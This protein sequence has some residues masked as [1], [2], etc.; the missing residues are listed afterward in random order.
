MFRSLIA[1]LAAAALAG[2][3][4][5]QQQP[6]GAATALELNP[7]GLGHLLVV[8]YFNTQ[9]GN[10]TLVNLFNASDKD[11]V[12]KIRYRS[13][14]NGDD[15]FS[16]QVFLRARAA[17]TTNVSTGANGLPAL[18]GVDRACTLPATVIG[19]PFRTT[20]LNPALTAAVRANEAREGYI[21]IIA[22]ADVIP[23]TALSAA[24]AYR[25][26]APLC[27]P[28]VLDGLTRFDA[29]LAPPTTGLMA[30]WILINV[31]QTTT[32]SGEAV[33]YEARA[34]GIAS[35][36]NNVFFPQ[37]AAP[38]TAAEVTQYTADPLYN[39]AQGGPIVAPASMDLP[40][41]STPYTATVASPQQQ[42]TE[43]SFEIAA[44]QTVVEYLTDPNIQASTDLVLSM[45]TRRYHV[46]VDYRGPTLITNRETFGSKNSIYFTGLGYSPSVLSSSGQTCYRFPLGFFPQTYDR[47]GNPTNGFSISPIPF[48]PMC[49]V[50]PVMSIMDELAS[51]PSKTLYASA[52]RV[53]LGWMLPPGT[54]GTTHFHWSYEGSQG[55]P[56]LVRQFARAVNPSAVPGVSG[57]YGFSSAGRTVLPGVPPQ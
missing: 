5:A 53:P 45:P 57:T 14:G 8:P 54:D 16:F 52:T 47:M 1:L 32:W 43:L 29:Q 38:L 42:A 21:E 55:L 15:L 39:F 30:N 51:P 41:L 20:R 28:S 12:V 18:I 46:A 4:H 40:D 2:S 50:V 22:M 25:A 13:A 10:A 35:T 23:N 26:P 9:G 44:Q 7:S 36:G 27:T 24:I 11:K 56:V 6:K 19:V 31:P 34:N 37:T 49:G 17:W 33:A 3:A 48:Y